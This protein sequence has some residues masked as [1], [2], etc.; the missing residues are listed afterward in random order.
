VVFARKIPE[1][2]IEHCFEIDPFCGQK[3][4]PFPEINPIILGEAR[5]S[6]HSGPVALV[7]A[8]EQYTFHEIQIL[9]HRC[10]MVLSCGDC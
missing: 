6:I 1:Y 2:F 5:D 10:V 4:K 3:R 9:A 8:M 7:D